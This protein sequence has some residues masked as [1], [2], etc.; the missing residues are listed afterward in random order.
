V[1]SFTRRTKERWNT[2]TLHTARKHRLY[3]P[4]Q[5]HAG[6]K[7]MCAKPPVQTCSRRMRNTSGGTSTSRRRK[8]QKDSKDAETVESGPHSRSVIST[9]T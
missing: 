3:W 7:K 4:A 9:L 5:A 2:Q 1:D 6:V 8:T